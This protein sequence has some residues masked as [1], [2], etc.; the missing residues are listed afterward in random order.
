MFLAVYVFYALN[1][2]NHENDLLVADLNKKIEN[3]SE[4]NTINEVNIQNIKKQI[5]HYD[6]E[7]KTLN[8]K[9]D[10]VSVETKK[11]SAKQPVQKYKKSDLNLLAQLIQSESGNQPFEGKLAVGTV[12]MNR[13]ESGKFPDTIRGVIF[14]KNQF[15]VVANGSINKEPSDES[16][17]AAKKVLE[18]S[19]VLESDVLYFYNPKLTNDKWIK[20]LKVDKKIGDHVFS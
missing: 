6:L 14:Q 12:V 9:I 8:A 5:E 18:G 10:S 15:S 16:L 11:V 2:I 3:L 1:T 20:S 13:V 17:E 7:N 4:S 19:R